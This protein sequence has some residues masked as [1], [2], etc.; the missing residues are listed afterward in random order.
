M[1]PDNLPLPTTAAETDV[2]RRRVEMALDQAAVSNRMAFEGK[3]DG[4]QVEYETALAAYRWARREL[5]R[6][7]PMAGTRAEVAVEMEA[8]VAG[9]TSAMAAA[10]EMDATFAEGTPVEW[11]VPVT[12]PK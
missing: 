7:D 8:V 6:L 3:V 12:E 11:N 4:R 10:K 9:E 5:D 1:P 2:I